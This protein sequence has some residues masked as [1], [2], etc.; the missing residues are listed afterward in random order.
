MCRALERL[1]NESQVLGERFMTANKGFLYEKALLEETEARSKKLQRL[2]DRL[3]RAGRKS[4]ETQSTTPRTKRKLHWAGGMRI[5]LKE[6]P[7]APSPLVAA[8]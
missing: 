5:P 3:T 2:Y 8:E 6:P 1:L 4:S 7:H